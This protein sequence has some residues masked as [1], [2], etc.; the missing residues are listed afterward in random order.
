MTQQ[1]SLE[2]DGSFRINTFAE[3]TVEITQAN[4]SGSLRACFGEKRSIVYFDS[5]APVFCV[6]NSR[7]FR[8]LEMI[9]SENNL[10]RDS[11]KPY[12]TITN[13]LEL[14]EKLV[15]DG[16]IT[17]TEIY[18]LLQ[19][20]VEFIFSDLLL[21][22][23]GEWNFNPLARVRADISFPIAFYKLLLEHARQMSAKQIS[24]RF[25]GMDETF[26]PRQNEE[27]LVEPQP[28]EAFVLSRFE[29][30]RLKLTEILQLC[31]LPEQA[32]LKTVY[33]LW[34][35]G[36]ITRSNWHPAFTDMKISSILSTRFE[37]KTQ[38]IKHQEPKK[39]APKVE[40]I[41]DV[42]IIEAIPLEEYLDRV[43]NSLS[44]YELLGVEQN[45]PLKLIRHSYF[46]LAKAFHPD[47]Y[48]REDAGKLRQIEQAFTTLAQ[49]H[50]VLKNADSRE[51]YDKKLAREIAEK[52]K[53]LEMESKG[54]PDDSYINSD[55]AAE[56]FE[57]GFRLLMDNKWEA[58]VPFLARAAHFSPRNAQYHAFF[59][60]ALSGDETQRH[61]AEGELQ[62]AIKL[63]PDNPSYRLMLAE[64]FVRNKLM[65]RAEG[66]LNRL[67]AAFPDNKEAAALLDSLRAK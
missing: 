23:D 24:T 32:G 53:R 36:L 15:S 30:G 56:D 18:S 27:E 34:L 19:R 9:I 16:L 45:A 7:N 10:D 35:A 52:Q 39:P 20:Q 42:P 38:A 31:G 51:S 11:L 54:E 41:Q 60:K 6:S 48:H 37:R 57:R 66:E 64:F 21:W 33:T 22:E 29:K 50:E 63:E 55:R 46:S 28:H 67:L 59:G 62:T 61:K 47:R 58:S 17:K 12:S 49:A 1:N 25:R 5:G 14:A 2:L 8:L 40:E 26:E 65:K 13:D 3:L 43:E 4:L 44:H